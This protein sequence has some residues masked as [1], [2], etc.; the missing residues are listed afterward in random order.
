MSNVLDLSGADTTGFDAIDP[1]KY[2]VRV[3]KVEMDQTKGTGKLGICPMVKIQLKVVD[4][5]FTD[6]IVFDQFVLPPKDAENADKMLGFFVRFLTAL[7][8]DEKVLKSKGFKLDN[9]Q[10][11][12]GREAVATVSREPYEGTDQNRVKGYKPA[13]SGTGGSSQGLI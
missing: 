9:L 13:G 10:D 11:L 8:L 4:G 3:H 12:V 1:G 7:G 2:N 5:E 6:R